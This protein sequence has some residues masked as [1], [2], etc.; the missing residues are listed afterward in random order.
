MLTYQNNHVWLTPPGA[1]T[2]L[3]A[4]LATEIRKF[5]LSTFHVEKQEPTMSQMF[6]ERNELLRLQ[7][8]VPQRSN[9]THIY[10]CLDVLQCMTV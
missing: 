5:P 7:L 10:S 2:L 9:T 4:A 8:I 1:P 6:T 3:G